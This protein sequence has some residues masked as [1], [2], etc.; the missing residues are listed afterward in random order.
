MK[1][2]NRNEGGGAV[3]L[4]RTI[5]RA[6]APAQGPQSGRVHELDSA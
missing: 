3:L 2:E 4:F 5:R 1:E 6:I